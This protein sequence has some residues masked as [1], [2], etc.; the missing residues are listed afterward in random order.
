[1]LK[2]LFKASLL[3]AS[4]L[5]IQF[6]SVNATEVTILD[7]SLVPVETRSTA[8]R[9]KAI[10]VALQ[11]VILKNSGAT[12]ALTNPI[13][14]ARVKSPNTL[15]S[16]Y[17]YH[18]IDGELFLKVNFDHKRILE[19]LR[20]AQL[21]VWGKQRPLT[22]I[23]LVEDLDGERS[24]LNDGSLLDSR[25]IFKLEAEAKG[26]PLIFPLMDLDDNM[27]ISIN[28]VRGMFVEQIEQASQR[29]QADYFVVASMSPNANGV[30]Y[31]V[32]L[33]AEGNDEQE[34]KTPLVTHR[35]VAVDASAAVT[36]IIST[37]SEYYVSRYAIADS[38]E[39]LNSTVTFVDISEMKQLVEIEK[40]LKQLSAV[41]AVNVSQMLGTR[42][43]YNLELFGSLEDLHRLMAL[44]PRVFEAESNNDG[45]MSSNN[46][47]ETSI[48]V[49]AQKLEYR[50]R[51]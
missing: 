36:G 16:Q 34:M 3:Y 48:V 46:N 21:P 9:N 20:E 12:A 23:W 50:W 1:M 8:E 38:G 22:L 42:V 6:N 35:Q 28:D 51:G 49:P 37:V 14:I 24:I 29:Y 2:T 25:Q 32:S 17:G 15:I 11:N 44:E 27:Q 19:L 7:E 43:T 47:I 26:V 31:S 41:K 4:C 13:I 30:E 5:F 40:Y 18:D 10:S 39:Q 45:D 33:F